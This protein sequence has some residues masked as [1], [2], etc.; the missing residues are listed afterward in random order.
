[1]GPLEIL[2]ILIVVMI[3]FGPRRVPEIGANLGK[4]MREFRRATT[5]MTRDFVSEI[6][7]ERSPQTAQTAS[8]P[9]SDAAPPALPA[10]RPD[11]R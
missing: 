3:V 11:D 7:K 6:E 1:M 10:G 5:E 9:P 8:Q 2:V 4:A